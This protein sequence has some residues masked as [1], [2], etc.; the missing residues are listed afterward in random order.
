MK[1]IGLIRVSTQVQELESQS[2]Q[3]KEA[4]IRDGYDESSI[5][6]I[7]DKESGCK[8]EEDRN[9]LTKLKQIIETEQIDAVYC[10]ELSRISRKSV[11]VYSIREYLINHKVNLICL[12]PYFRL[13]KNDGT[14]DEN[15]NLAFGIF[16]TMAE[17]ET[18][19][20]K[21][22]MMRG[23]AKKTAEGKLSVGQPLYG[24][25]LD[26]K[27]R[28]IPHPS[29]SVFVK[30]I[31]DRYVNK[32]ESS[33]SIAR[34]LYLR[35][36]FRDDSNKVL[37]IQ[38]YVCVVLREKRYAGLVENSI[39]PP[40]VTREL[41][42]SAEEIRKKSGSRF[43]RKSNTK[44]IYPLQGYL[45]TVDGYR[46]TIGVT[47]NRYLKMNDAAVERISLNMTAA[48][49]LA[50]IV[51]KKYLERGVAEEDNERIR[52]EL[53]E[54]INVNKLKIESIL[55]KIE[56]ILKEND[57]IN[58]RIIKGRLS[59]EKGDALIDD[60][61]RQMQSLEDEKQDLEYQNLKS[62]NTLLFLANPIFTKN[63]ENYDMST[64]ESLRE[65]IVK[66][67]DKVIVRK[68]KF[69]TYSLEFHFLDGF[70]C[71]YSFYS[72]NRGVHFYN[73]KGE[74]LVL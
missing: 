67:L 24:Y 53:H 37:T 40:L 8:N 33:G 45:Y 34:D 72:I 63:E 26:S 16:S 44:T 1:A 61:L 73:E 47:N 64:N 68:I 9:G 18:F 55:T 70:Q 39:Y 59:E 6:L 35:K 13:L 5:I 27:H 57:Y 25:T 74:E 19:I 30:E 43:H 23:K 65:L 50:R 11:I 42:N 51:I 38:N 66:Y 71:I 36:A 22:R 14:F 15:S 48:D 20:R 58:L 54:S 52:K 69:S 4:I 41:F 28:P 3:V 12:N 29:E 7:E 31:F 60:N 10:Y 21:A 49:N 2:K 46:L 17:N 56:S 32:K 62:E